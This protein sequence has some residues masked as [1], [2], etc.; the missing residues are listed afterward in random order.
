MF[1]QT[2]SNLKKYFYIWQ[3][4]IALCLVS[5]SSVA[6]ALPRC[7]WVSSYHPGYEWQ[8]GISRGIHYVLDGKCELKTFHMDTKT[9]QTKQHIAKKAA[10]ARELIS[11]YQPDVVIVSDDNVSKYLVAPYY[12]NTSIP[13][14]FCGVNWSAHSYG[15]PFENT[16]GI[17]EVAP[18]TPLMKAVKEILPNNQGRLL[19]L[20]ANTNT[21]HKNAKF[22]KRHFAYNQYQMDVKYVKDSQAWKKAF[23]QAQEY[24][25]ILLLNN[26]G[27]ASWDKREMMDF[28]KANNT[29]LTI[30]FNRWMAP[31]SMLVFT[32]IAEEQG[33]WAA[34]M[35]LEILNGDEVNTIPIISNQ[36]WNEYINLDLFKAA[37]IVPPQ[38]LLEKA[39]SV[40]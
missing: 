23:L 7:L 11:H 10:Q 2:N 1:K 28:V 3:F 15:Y 33:E 26:S 16:T 39:V 34:K 37:G 17:L 5:V 14:V 38:A 31:Y 20:A 35:A 12:K 19:F 21:A 29:S 30:S 27:I 40:R 13:F 24:D 22:Y 36:T 18:V 32:K 6:Q 9:N 25:L 8:D 4:F